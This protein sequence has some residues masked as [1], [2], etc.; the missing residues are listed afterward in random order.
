VATTSLS[1]SSKIQQDKELVCST[2]NDEVVMLSIEHGKYFGLDS[3]GSCIWE[4]ISTPTL[5]S[6]VLRQML[7][8]FDTDRLT[9]ENEVIEF[10][11]EMIEKQIVKIVP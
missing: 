5:V 2:I 8:M 10:L 11:E 4:K 9:C 3:V 6:D 7:D 1:L